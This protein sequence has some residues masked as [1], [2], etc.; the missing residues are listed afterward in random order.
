[1][2][3]SYTRNHIHLVFSTKERRNIIQKEMQPKLWAYLAGVSKNYE[4]IAVAIGGTEN[5]VHIL[6]HLSPKLALA[7]AVQFLKG[8]SSKW[9][10]EQGIE[11]LWQEGYGAFSAS[12][13][14]LDAVARYIR[15]QEAHHRK[16]SFEEEFR[17]ILKKHGV[18]YDPK[19]VL[20]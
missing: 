2:A 18:E 1:M 7:K 13:S 20:G 11:F 10:G 9:M 15:T 12:S 17:A 5:H 4:M 3:H 8:N 6:F 14:N 19:Y 16:F